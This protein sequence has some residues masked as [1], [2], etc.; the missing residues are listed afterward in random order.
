[1]KS[2]TL[3]LFCMSSIT[4]GVAMAY[5]AGTCTPHRIYSETY[6]NSKTVASRMRPSVTLSQEWS[7]ARIIAAFGLTHAIADGAV[8]GPD[9]TQKT[10]RVRKNKISILRSVSTGLVIRVNRGHYAGYWIVD[11]C[12]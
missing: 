12:H 9:G 5:E 6:E 10:Y 11:Y 2:L 3:L 4:S 7:D 8:Q 1:M